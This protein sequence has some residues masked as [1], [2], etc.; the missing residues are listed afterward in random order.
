VLRASWLEDHQWLFFRRQTFFSSQ[1]SRRGRKQAQ[2]FL[3][4]A[5]RGVLRFS[6]SGCQRQAFSI[7]DDRGPAVPARQMEFLKLMYR[8]ESRTICQGR[9]GYAR[10][11]A[12]AYPGARL[13]R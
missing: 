4:F 7:F 9:D 8:M 2:D 11:D 5:R 1:V 13:L 10:A 12:D 6:R 3:S